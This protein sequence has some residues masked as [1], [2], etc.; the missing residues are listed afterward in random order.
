MSD[1]ASPGPGRAIAIEG[2]SGVGKSSLAAALEALGGTVRIPEAFD[3][4]GRPRAL[5]FRGPRSLRAIEERLLAE[6]VRRCAEMAER[7]SRGETVVLDTATVGPLTYT[8]AL[9]ALEPRLAPAGPPLFAHAT[10]LARSGALGLPDVIVYLDLAPSEIARRIARDPAGHPKLRA[11]RHARVAPFER[12]LWLR[13]IRSV[14]PGRVV[15]LRAD[16]PTEALA[17]RVRR[18][19]RDRPAGP[20]S[21]GTMLRAIRAIARAA[22]VRASALRARPRGKP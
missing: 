22:D 7:R 15:V 13:E 14:V 17:R 5:D 1:R 20:V 16:A 9:I 2:P 3:R 21:R 8:A 10:R 6:E 18:L 11:A 4:L 19:G 12:R